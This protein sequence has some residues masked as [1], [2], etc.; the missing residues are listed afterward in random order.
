[1]Q[2]A[3]EWN[4]ALLG[5]AESNSGGSN[6]GAMVGARGCVDDLNNNTYMIT[7]AWQGMGPVS[8]SNAANAAITCGSG[9][10]NGAAGSNCTNDSCRR[11]VTMT[12]NIATL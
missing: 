2:D 7:V 1:V 11:T 4:N 9:L 5:A 3:C 8:V 12:V 10:Y 6:V